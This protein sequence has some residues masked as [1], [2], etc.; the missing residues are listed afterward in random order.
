MNVLSDILRSVHLSGG[1]HFR[2]E[3]SA[4]WGMEMK[5]TLA[6]EFHVIVRGSCWLRVAGHREPVLLQG[7][8]FVVLPHGDAHSLVDTP[9]SAA[10]PAEDIVHGQNLENYGPVTYGGRGAV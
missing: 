4:P 3:F 5:P 2:C 10:R 6:A 9:D 8:D 1:V 7:G